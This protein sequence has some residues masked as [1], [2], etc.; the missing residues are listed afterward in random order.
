MLKTSTSNDLFLSATI[1]VQMASPVIL[2]AVLHESRTGSIPT[3]TPIIS[4]GRPTVVNTKVKV[5]RPENGTDGVLVEAIIT[6]KINVIMAEV[7]NQFRNIG[8]QTS[9]PHFA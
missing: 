1:I 2:T 4:T 5:A 8:L 6:V 3:I 7:L 9:P